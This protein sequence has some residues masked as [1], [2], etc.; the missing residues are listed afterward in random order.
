ML[1]LF[2]SKSKT[3]T[4]GDPCTLPILINKTVQKEYI[5]FNYLNELIQKDPFKHD[6]SDLFEKLYPDQQY[7]IL[8]YT[9]AASCSKIILKDL[10]EAT[11]KYLIDT[12]LETKAPAPEYLK[13]IQKNHYIKAS[14]DKFQIATFER[15]LKRINRNDLINS[16]VQYAIWTLFKPELHFESR[17]LFEED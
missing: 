6:I 15:M 3:K 13:K 8:Y 9:I 11:K 7:A 12:K 1:N 17:L 5:S 2:S 16:S 10:E 4:G 14:N